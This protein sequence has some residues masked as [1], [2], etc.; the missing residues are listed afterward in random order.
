MRFFSYLRVE[1]IRLLRSRITIFF[2]LGTALC[3]LIGYSIYQPAGTGT[4]AALVVANPLLA[5]ALGGA[6]LFA[7][8]TLLELNRAKKECME[9][10][11]DSIISP[12]LFY[13]VKTVSLLFAALLSAVF[14]SVLY[15]PYAWIRLGETFQLS[16]YFKFAAIFL[17][18]M[19]V[20]AVLLTAALYQ[21][22]R[23]VD[24]GFIGFTAVMLIGIGPWNTGTYLG[25]WIDLSSV[26]FSG[27]LGNTSIYR[28]AFYSRMI[29]LLL[30]GGIWVFSLLC[31]RN[32]GKR[33]LGSFARNL[34][35]IYLPIVTI[36]LMSVSAF[37]YA[38]QPYM[39]HEEPLAMDDTGI[40]TGGGM[41]IYTED[42]EENHQEV[43]LKSIETDLQFD[44][45]RGILYGETHYHM[46]NGSNQSQECLLQVSSGCTIESVFIN[47][48]EVP[49]TD[50]END[51]FVILKDISL[52]L[53]EDK[54]LDVV[55]HYQCSPQIPANTGTLTLY[56]EITP[57]YISM[58][59]PHAIPAFQNIIESEEC[60]YSGQVTLPTGMELISGGEQPQIDHDNPDGTTVWNI[61]GQG[62]SVA[63]F[64]GNYIR[65]K[66]S[67]SGFPVYFCYSKTHQ[68]E[69]EQLDIEQL[70]KETISYC[71]AHYGE[72]PY[73]EDYPL[74]IVM[75]SAHMMGGGAKENL[76]YMGETFFTASNLNDPSKGGSAAE[77]IAHEIIHQW[78]GIQCLIVD[79]ENTD[80]S[81][82]A[83]TCYTTYRMMKELRGQE[84]AQEFYIDVW[85]E[86][87]DNMTDNFYIRNSEYLTMLSEEQQA[88]LNALIFDACTYAKA[89]LQILKAEQLVGGEEEIDKILKSLFQNGGTEM[90]PYITWQDFL[91][92]CGVTEEQL[93]LEGDEN[94]G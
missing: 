20:M 86:K 7:S 21:F 10:I 90:P 12:M 56:Y 32:H 35:K 50:L 67:D 84:Y 85:K 42:E 63:I 40:S 5:G 87:Y 36:L 27:D 3:P 58:G 70:L 25:Y 6:F 78:W 26:G 46:E 55:I 94:I 89:P 9:H 68:K 34:Y 54:N 13:A 69:F 53:P 57:E 76:S 60:T 18:P 79:M 77:V 2:F 65:T 39:D 17:F 47:G 92:A 71:T 14:T 91:D 75:T 64:A 4:T 19:F 33:L 29:W 44:T 73:T 80:W 31:V 88:T 30:F 62:R 24:L 41:T 15:I 83:L 74:N 66:I 51:Y 1:S 37:L 45:Q 72:L 82:E 49:F 61:Q 22:F 93:N 48:E 81:S 11:T 59:G 16:E 52:T 38:K 28:M 43:L 23:R 8:L